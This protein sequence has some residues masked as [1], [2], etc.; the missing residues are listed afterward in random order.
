MTRQPSS[1]V[2][3]TLSRS[4]TSA[5]MANR[6]GP[7][8]GSAARLVRTSA[9]CT[10]TAMRS[11]SA[12]TTQT[13]ATIRPSFRTT[14]RRRRPRSSLKRSTS[15]RTAAL[16]TTGAPPLRYPSSTRRAGQTSS[17]RAPGEGAGQSPPTSAARP[18]SRARQ[19]SPSLA[20]TPR[21][22][23]PAASSKWSRCTRSS[24]SSS[25]R[26]TPLGSRP[27]TR[28]CCAAPSSPSSASPRRRKRGASVP[29]QP[30][31]RTRS[32]RTASQRGGSTAR[33]R[34]WC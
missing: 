3:S 31:P 10:G 24:P 13:L 20:P 14:R 5:L 4:S 21:R 7:R 6:S 34:T 12:T 30:T 2:R 25:A 19:S 1:P 18:P 22:A 16:A 27:P 17:C 15:A 26:P 29:A 28:G 32:R 9:A 33:L 23:S 8:M 11:A